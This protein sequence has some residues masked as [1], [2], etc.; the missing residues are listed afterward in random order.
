MRA[1]QRIQP[2]SLMRR[3]GE[4]GDEEEDK[5]DIEDENNDLME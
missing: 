3:R 4:N 5:H 2:S 1:S